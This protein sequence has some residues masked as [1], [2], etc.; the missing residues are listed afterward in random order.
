MF[1]FDEVAGK[2]SQIVE[3]ERVNQQLSEENAQLREHLKAAQKVIKAVKL[4]RDIP[5]SKETLL[6]W[7]KSYEEYEQAHNG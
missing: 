1:G 5:N 3:L 6:R 4:F 7:L 2:E